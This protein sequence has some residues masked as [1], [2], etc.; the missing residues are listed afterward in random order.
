MNILITGGTGMIGSALAQALIAEGHKVWVLTRSPGGGRI[1]AGAQPLGWDGR[2]PRGW[3]ERLS[4]MDAVV[5]LA[6]ATIGQWPWTAARKRVLVESR[7]QA[8]RAVA[9]AIEAASP[10]P[11]VLIQSSGINYYG[12]RGEERIGEDAPPGHDFL[13]RLAA[14]WEESSRSVEALGV[15]RVVVRT[16]IVLDAHAGVLPL[17]ALPVRLFAGGPLG[18]G[19]QGLPWIHLHDQV[20]ALRFVLENE[21][22]AGAF[23]FCAPEV[24]SSGQFIRTLARVLRRPYWLPAPAFA[25]K[26]ALGGMSETLLHGQ[27]AEPRR[28]LALGYNFKFPSLESAL[29]DIY[30]QAG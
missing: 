28:L 6:G 7:V 4:E 3:G 9:Q 11:K 26:L 17:M 24:V 29:R 8:G 20:D 22:A 14:E 30:N 23:N 25:L 18:S 5:N 13:G 15:R 2:T 10:R 19:K 12:L 27:F 16:A 1:P 21:Q